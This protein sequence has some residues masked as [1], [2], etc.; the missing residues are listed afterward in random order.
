[1][2]N[3]EEVEEIVGEFLKLAIINP[4]LN[5]HFSLVGSDALPVMNYGGDSPNTIGET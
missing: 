5:E 2:M 1:M 3:K 4:I